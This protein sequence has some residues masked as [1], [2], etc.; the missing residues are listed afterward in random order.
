MLDRVPPTVADVPH[1]S[2]WDCCVGES[3]SDLRPAGDRSGVHC[4][5]VAHS[6]SGDRAL[7]QLWL[8]SLLLQPL[9]GPHQASVQGGSHSIGSLVRNASWLGALSSWLGT[10]MQQTLECFL[11]KSLQAKPQFR[12]RLEEK[13]LLVVGAVM[14][15]SYNTTDTGVF[16]FEAPTGKAMYVPWDWER[17]ASCV[18]H[19]CIGACFN[20]LASI[21]WSICFLSPS[22][23]SHNF[24][25]LGRCIYACKDTSTFLIATVFLFYILQRLVNLVDLLSVYSFIK[26]IIN[27]G[28]LL[29]AMQQPKIALCLWLNEVYQI[30]GLL[31]LNPLQFTSLKSDQ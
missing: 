10:R 25:F 14:L 30:K 21:Y 19:F 27:S 9:W 6:W 17:Y 4:P 24:L 22:L 26:K 18:A 3:Q 16:S 5:A 23:Q 20:I 29:V 28:A 15:G 1:S 11:F 12:V 2:E 7:P 31:K 13:M 8:W